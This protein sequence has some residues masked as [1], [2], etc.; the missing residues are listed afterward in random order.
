M[1]GAVTTTMVEN[2]H[3]TALLPEGTVVLMSIVPKRGGD[4]A[5]M[6]VATAIHSQPHIQMDTDGE[7]LHPRKLTIVNGGVGGGGSST[8]GGS[9]G[10]EGNEHVAF[11]I[12][13]Q[14][15]EQ[16]QEHGDEGIIDRD[17]D[18]GGRDIMED[19]GGME[20]IKDEDVKKKL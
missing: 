13:Q 5:T 17:D 8:G 15:Q 3:A 9:G 14:Q 18:D 6:E 12:H 4:T 10:V 16:Q 19:D 11:L 20:D 7:A 2:G 1:S